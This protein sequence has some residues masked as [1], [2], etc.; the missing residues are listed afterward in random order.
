MIIISCYGKDTAILLFDADKMRLYRSD[1][2]MIA[3][4]LQKYDYSE[5]YYQRFFVIFALKV[6]VFSEYPIVGSDSDTFIVS[7]H[8]TILAKV[9]A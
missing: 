6:I 8:V 7:F 5:K 2:P 9:I 3:L 4:F 1:K